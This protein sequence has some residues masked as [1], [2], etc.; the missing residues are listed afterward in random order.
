[1]KYVIFA[2]RADLEAWQT[3]V[4]KALGYPRTA[5]ALKRVG[6]GPH[7]T[8]EAPKHF[9][10]PLKHRLKDQWA[11]PLPDGIDPPKGSKVVEVLPEGWLRK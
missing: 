3:Q 4:D 5:K 7:P 2:N 1:M 10:G 8:C 6:R 9:G 11:L